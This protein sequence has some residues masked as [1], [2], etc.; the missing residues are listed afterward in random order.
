MIQLPDL[1]SATGGRHVPDTRLGVVV[2]HRAPDPTFALVQWPHLRR[3]VE[4][5]ARPSAGQTAPTLPKNPS[6]ADPDATY[7]VHGDDKK[8]FGYNVSVAVTNNFVR[9]IQADTGAQPD[10]VAIPDLTP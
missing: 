2:R 7:R 10:P 4:A 9:E 5:N 8:D 3:P 6:S 1:S